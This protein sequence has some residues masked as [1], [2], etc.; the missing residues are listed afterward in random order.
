MIQ[1]IT[2]HPLALDSDDHHFPDGV[3]L[4]NHCNPWFVQSINQYFNH[5]KINFL[6]L[7]CAG[8]GLVAGMIDHGHTSVGLE[9]SDHCLNIKSEVIEKLGG[10]PAGHANWSKYGNTNLFTC[11]ITYDYQITQNNVPMQFDLITC[12]DVMEHFYEERIENF[13]RMVQ[14]HLKPT[15]LFVANIALFHLV[16]DKILEAGQVE[17]HKSLF[18]HDKWLSMISPYLVEV[19]YPF[20]C[21]NRTPATRSDGSNLIYAGKLR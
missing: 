21:T 8:G 5:E 9:G 10:M 18:S 20:S 13:L 7:G 2:N 11:D 17:Y 4:D 19:D 6:D 3:H 12:F 16:K 15:G 14:R 1:V